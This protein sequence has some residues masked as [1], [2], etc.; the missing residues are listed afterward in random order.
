MFR[1][2]DV[3]RVTHAIDTALPPPYEASVTVED[4]RKTL[5]VIILDPDH[6]HLTVA[7]T[8]FHFQEGKA[9]RALMQPPQEELDSMATRLAQ[10]CMAYVPPVPAEE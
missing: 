4:S 7:Q 10:L 6:E 8:A 5:R 9:W 2:S 1:Q 3:R